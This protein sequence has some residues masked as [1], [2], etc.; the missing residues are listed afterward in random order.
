[1]SKKPPVT[2][3]PPVPPRPVP[4]KVKVEPWG[5]APQP[6]AA[7]SSGISSHASVKASLGKARFRL[8]NVQLIDEP[9]DAKSSRLPEPP[10]RIQATFYDYTNHRTVKAVSNIANRRGVE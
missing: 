7:H 5:P 9:A 10:S 3:K 2:K 1:M 6:I 8:L 4:L